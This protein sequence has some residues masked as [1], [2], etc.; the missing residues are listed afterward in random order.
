M[1]QAKRAKSEWKFCFEA[2][3]WT[4][5]TVSRDTDT[6]FQDHPG[7]WVRQQPARL[8]LP[9]PLNSTEP[10][11]PPGLLQPSKI[12]RFSRTGY[13]DTRWRYCFKHLYGTSG[14]SLNAR[15]Y[16]SKYLKYNKVPR[17]KV[18]WLK[19]NDNIGVEFSA[20]LLFAEI[21]YIELEFYLKQLLTY[22]EIG[23]I[24]WF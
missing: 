12:L 14:L 19:E 15:N 11:S 20:W 13:S 18:I 21:Y 4:Y 23:K 3:E 1:H 17:S 16:F 24:Y 10:R 22:T 5:L 2:N 6:S 7:S 9:W 8:V